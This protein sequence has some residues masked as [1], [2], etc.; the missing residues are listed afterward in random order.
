MFCYTVRCEFTADN[1]SVVADWLA[2]LIPGHIQD[3]IDAGAISAE[4][5]NIDG[6]CPTFEIRYRFSSRE[7][8]LV[9]EENHAPRLRTEGLE[10]FPASLGLLY[11]RTTGEQVS[12][13][14]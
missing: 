4:V 3:V 8:F 12:R 7:E 5:I 13:S 2:W 14:P 11:S 10:K 6:D 1:P 9:Y